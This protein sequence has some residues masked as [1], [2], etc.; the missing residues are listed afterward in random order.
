MSVLDV[1]RSL[2]GIEELR[3]RSQALAMCEA[4][5]SPGWE[6]RYYSYDCR[7]SAER[8]EHMASMRNGSGDEYAIVFSPAGVYV[9]G[10]DH[11]ARPVPGL[12]DDVPEVFAA[13]VAEPAFSHGSNVCLWRLTGDE[14]WHGRGLDETAWL[15]ELLVEGTAEAYQ[16]FAEDYYEEDVDVAAVA[17]VFALRPLTDALVRRLNPAVTVGYLADDIEEIGYPR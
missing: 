4:I 5:I 10:L 1:A 15:F 11:E 17:E 13:Q 2:P 9:R 16:E 6:S 14:R 8:G 3:A 12:F 7:W